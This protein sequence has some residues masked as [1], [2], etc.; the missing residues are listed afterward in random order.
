MENFKG[1]AQKEAWIV[2]YTDGAGDR[3]IRTFAR[4]RE[5]DDYDATVGVEV[6]QGVHTAPNKSITIARAADDWIKYIELE[7]RE[8]STVAQ[9]RQHVKH[10]TKRLGG[11]KLASLTTPRINAFRD[12]LLA[13][14]S[15]PLARKALTSLKS[16][17]RDARGGETWPKT[18]R[19]MSRSA[20]ISEASAS[21]RWESI[22]RRRT[23][24]DGFLTRHP[25][26]NGARCC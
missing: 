15:R 5:A 6:R 3:H 7:G 13:N 21:S 4:K 8:R 24:S 9:Y 16:L 11:H 19:R 17:L 25:A 22:F 10:I 26:A 12:D 14:M 20:S 1:R 2:D 18:W 23:R